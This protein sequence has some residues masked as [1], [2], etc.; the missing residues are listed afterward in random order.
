MMQLV[1]AKVKIY[2]TSLEAT[3]LLQVVQALVPL[4][5]IKLHLRLVE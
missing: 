2:S 1:V 4:Q 5:P 3:K